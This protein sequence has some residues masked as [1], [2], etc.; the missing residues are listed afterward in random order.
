[1]NNKF[2]SVPFNFEISMVLGS[3]YGNSCWKKSTLKGLHLHGVQK[4]C[5]LEKPFIVILITVSRHSLWQNY[6]FE[7]DNWLQLMADENKAHT[8]KIEH[9][10]TF[11]LLM[12]L[13]ERQSLGI[14]C[15]KDI[16]EVMSNDRWNCMVSPW[17]IKLDIILF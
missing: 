5:P 12:Q 15:S 14:K 9:Y 16:L 11:C 1:M 10:Y 2:K 4:M 6:I 7:T 3:L 13:K 8:R 17:L